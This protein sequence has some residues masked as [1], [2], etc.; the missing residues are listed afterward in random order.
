[1]PRCLKDIVNAQQVHGEQAG[2]KVIF[3]GHS[4]QM[5]NSGDAFARFFNRIKVSDVALNELI[6][7]FRLHWLDVKQPEG[8]MFPQKRHN[9]RSNPAARTSD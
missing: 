1:L 2:V 6:V 3:V 8:K 5:K 4:R 7:T 9:L